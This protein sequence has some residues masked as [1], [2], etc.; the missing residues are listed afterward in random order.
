M[1]VVVHKNVAMDENIEAVMVIFQYFEKLYF[2]GILDEYLFSFIT[3]ACY[4][5]KSTGVFYSERSSHS[6]RIIKS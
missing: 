3:P 5:I 6:R 1:I 4:V 2:I